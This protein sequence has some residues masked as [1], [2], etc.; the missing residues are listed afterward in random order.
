[1]GRRLTM[2]KTKEI[3]R[4]RW[5]LG[6]SVRETARSLGVSTGVVSRTT[7]RASA[8]ELTWPEVEELPPEELEARIYRR[9]AAPMGA[10]AEPDP[11]WIHRELRRP[12]VTLQRLH[13]EYLVEHPSGYRYTAF[14][15]RYRRWKKRQQPSMRQ[16][17][18]AGERCFVDY[19]GKKPRLLEPTSG[20]LVEV[21]LF[22]GVLGASNL[23]YA[24][25]TRTQRS[26]DFIGSH[27]RMLEY[28]GGAPSMLVPDQLRAAVSRPSRVEPAIQRT[29][30]ELARHYGTAVVPARPYRPRDKAKVEGAVLIAQRYLLAAI[31]NEVFVSL[32]ALN[33]RLRELLDAL[34]ARKTRS[35]GGVSR[36]ELFERLEKGAL[37]PLPD[38]PFEHAEWKQPKVA[39]DYHVQLDGHLYSVPH[40]LI[41]ERVEAR[42][43]AR[44]VEVFFRGRRVATHA[45]SREKHRHTTEPMHMPHDHRAW[46]EQDPSDLLG[47]AA[48]VGPFTAAFAERL[49]TCQAVPVTGWRSARGL[50]RLAESYS[51]ERLEQACRRA[52]H[53]GARSYRPVK[54]MLAHGLDQ[55]PLPGEAPADAEPLEHENVRG[56]DYYLH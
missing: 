22:V 18:R 54:Q 48:Q 12:G 19:S 7:Y 5:S 51:P 43:T 47:R 10:R 41:G 9:A 53:F 17:H 38:A 30:A 37:T 4:L 33:A 29:Y 25:A 35:L 21:E 14:C 44:V 6:L 20:E 42:L 45:R 50:L 27:V 32:A 2:R 28:F 3:L 40:R 31:R 13:L 36:R 39:P 49:L 8:A 11:Q 34:N 16:V 55:R 46:L 15:E 24:E 1:M 23:T 52:L 26:E 56:P